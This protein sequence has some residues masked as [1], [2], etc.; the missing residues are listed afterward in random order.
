LADLLPV[1][2]PERTVAEVIGRHRL[3]EDWQP[4]RVEMLN[5][6]GGA[7]ALEWSAPTAAGS[8]LVRIT[9]LEG[10]LEIFQAI[11]DEE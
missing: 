1:A 3:P 6:P 7:Y 10:D 2:R 9:R 4:E 5:H 11:I 8:R